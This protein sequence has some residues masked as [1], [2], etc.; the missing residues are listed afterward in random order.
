MVHLQNEGDKRQLGLF[1]F[2]KSDA[3]ALVDKVSVATAV[4]LRFCAMRFLALSS[5]CLSDT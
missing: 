4:I 3:Q 2:N 5:F 1:F